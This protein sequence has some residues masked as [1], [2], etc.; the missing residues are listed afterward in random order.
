MQ[1]TSALYDPIAGSTPLQLLE[2]SRRRAR[3]RRIEALAKPDTGIVLLSASQ[4]SATSTPRSVATTK[5]ALEIPDRPDYRCM[6]FYRLVYETEF[7]LPSILAAKSMGPPKIIDIQKACADF[8]NVRM[9]DILS[10]RRTA[11]VV[12]PRQVAMF[13][14]KEIT[15]KSLPEIGRYFDGRDHTTVLYAIRKIGALVLSD[16]AVALDVVAISERL[17]IF[18]GRA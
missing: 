16:E 17:G 13:L 8:Y 15:G 9:R 1:G 6:W 4:R 12:R 10:A 7:L 2:A 18:N 11:I 3:Q 14:V 5:I